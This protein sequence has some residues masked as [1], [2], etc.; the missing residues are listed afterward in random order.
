VPSDPGSEGHHEHDGGSFEGELGEKF[1]DERYRSSDALWSDEANP[2][3]VAEV[4]GM[5]P[6]AALDVGCGEGADAIWLARQGWRVTAIDISGVA[7]ER[8]AAAARRAGTE[9]ADRITWERCDLGERTPGGPFDLV[10][11]QFMHLPE[12]ERA[13]LH[14]ALAAAVAPGGALLIVGHDFS[15][16]ATGLRRPLWPG[17]FPGAAEVGADLA[18]EEWDVVVAESRA[19]PA[20]GPDGEQVTVHDAVLRAERRS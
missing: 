14:T 20:M 11:A 4:T 7:L 15:D 17:H 2:Q 1:W 8:A 9:V 10:S 19:R 5:A 18:P 13:R 16:L 3:L 12:P 6:G